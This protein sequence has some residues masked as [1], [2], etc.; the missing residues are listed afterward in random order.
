EGLM[1]RF[2]FNIAAL[3]GLIFACGVAFASLKE[4]SE[5]WESAVFSLTLVV[6]LVA[7]LLAIHR[8][9][10]RRHFWLGFALFGGCY[11]GISLIPPIEARLITSKGLAFLHSKLPG[12]QSASAGGTV[13]SGWDSPAAISQVVA[14]SPQGSR[15]AAGGPG[16]VRIWDAVT[17][18]V[19]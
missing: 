17:G 1:Q 12:Q 9:G 18:K 13:I 16:Q 10:E 14:F 7:A 11:L 8:I 3:V 19:I 4:S 2:R 6:I 5:L 15:I